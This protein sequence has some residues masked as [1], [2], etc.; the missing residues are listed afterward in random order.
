MCDVLLGND[1]RLRLYGDPY[2]SVR[3]LSGGKRIVIYSSFYV[4]FLERMGYVSV[5]IIF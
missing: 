2:F 1:V 5:V 3:L 4:V